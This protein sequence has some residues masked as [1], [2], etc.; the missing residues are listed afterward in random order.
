MKSFKAVFKQIFLQKVKYI[1]LVLLIQIITIIL[2]AL[3]SNKGREI[4]TVL[5][6]IG[7]TSTVIADL[8]ITIILCWQNE[9]INSSQTWQLILLASSAKYI[10]NVLSSVLGCIYIFI[11]QLLINFILL[12]PYLSASPVP[13][14]INNLEYGVVHDYFQLCV[15]LF[16]L[17]LVIFT[18][19]S[20]VNFLSYLIIN[21]LPTNTKWVRLLVIV[22]LTVVATYIFGSTSTGSISDWL[23]PNV[24]YIIDILIFGG[25]DLWLINKYVESK[26]K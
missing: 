26:I 7:L 17:V 10:A 6:E 11:I 19:V 4:N 16:L 9:R 15:S 18:F 20:F 23:K 21:I 12:L 22:V 8:V 5:S 24:Q 3:F 25:F 1:H 2:L 14:N 13:I